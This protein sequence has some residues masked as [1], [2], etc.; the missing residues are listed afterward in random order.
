MINTIGKNIKS[1]IFSFFAGSII[2]SLLLVLQEI[3]LG[4]KI[5]F[6]FAFFII[7]VIVSQS[8]I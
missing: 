5:V 6:S 7:P 1:F 8:K 3:Y 2:L 4:H